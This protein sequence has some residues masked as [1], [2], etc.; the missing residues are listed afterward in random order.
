MSQKTDGPFEN[1]CRHKHNTQQQ[2]S[3]ALRTI[4]QSECRHLQKI[5]M[6]LWSLSKVWVLFTAHLMD[7]TRAENDS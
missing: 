3:W 4:A 5:K 2:N 6:N 7:D 1:K